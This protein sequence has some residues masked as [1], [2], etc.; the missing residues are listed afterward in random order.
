M[1]YNPKLK[2]RPTVYK[3]IQMRSRLE[4]GFAQWLD[5]NHIDWDYEP[6]C[7]ASEAGQYLPDFEVWGLDLANFWENPPRVFIE[8]KHSGW[9]DLSQ[10]N[11]SPFLCENPPVAAYA[12]RMT[13]ILD[14]TPK[15]VVLMC[16][17]G[18]VWALTSFRY[19]DGRVIPGMWPCS[20]APGPTVVRWKPF[21]EPWVGE[22]W[23]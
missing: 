5:Q 20:W 1:T 12:K 3:G 22:W 19:D 11:W 18:A 6:E 4:A 23:A 8:V 2:A 15:A 14:S 17:P 16:Q 7:F 9:N 10:D 21:M 13:A